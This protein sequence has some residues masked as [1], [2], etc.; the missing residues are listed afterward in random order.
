[1]IK[2]QQQIHMLKLGNKINLMFALNAMQTFFKKHTFKYSLWTNTH[3][4]AHLDAQKSQVSNI[5][6]SQGIAQHKWGLLNQACVFNQPCL[7]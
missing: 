3:M 5:C 7:L 1:M 4:N 2:T 6:L